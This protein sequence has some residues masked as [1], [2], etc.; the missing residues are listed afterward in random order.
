MAARGLARRCA[1]QPVAEARRSALLIVLGSSDVGVA[2][3]VCEPY[4]SSNRAAGPSGVLSDVLAGEASARGVDLP[5]E[6]GRFVCEPVRAG[7]P[8]P[9]LAVRRDAA[10]CVAPGFHLRSGHAPVRCS[11]PRRADLR[12]RMARVALATGGRL[13][14]GAPPFVQS[15]AATECPPVSLPLARA[16]AQGVGRRR[17]RLPGEDVTGR[18]YCRKGRYSGPSPWGGRVSSSA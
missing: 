1:P 5:R 4:A 10:A 16:F 8:G 6:P 11:Q 7:C 3:G 18:Q 9:L 14:L 2:S 15:F 13:H 12:L 17:H